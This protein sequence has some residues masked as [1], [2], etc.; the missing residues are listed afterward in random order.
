MSRTSAFERHKE[1]AYAKHG[2]DPNKPP[3]EKKEKEKPEKKEIVVRGSE[4]LNKERPFPKPKRTEP[5]ENGEWIMPRINGGYTKITFENGE[6][7]GPVSHWISQ[8][9]YP[10]ICTMET[11]YQHNVLHGPCRTYNSHGVLESTFTYSHGKIDGLLTQY[12][13]SGV[14]AFECWYVN[15]IQ[16][17]L[18]RCYDMYGDI[19]HECMYKNGQKH[20]RSVTYFP[21]NGG[22]C[23]VSHFK[24]GLPVDEEEMFYTDGQ[25]RQTIPFKK[26]CPIA[27]PTQLDQNGKP[28]NQPSKT[29]FPKRDPL[30]PHAPW[31]NSEA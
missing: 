17:E 7:H 29:P 5:P 26:G 8:E 6:K 10:D 1:A 15:G 14:K 13:P 21:Q 12:Q 20:G 4:L 23:Q 31:D 16:E 28:M 27:Y 30:M 9:V 22:V 24:D 2:I 25:L 18:M 3:K 11:Y 19:N